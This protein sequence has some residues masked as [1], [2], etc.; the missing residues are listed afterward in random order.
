[1]TSTPEVEIREFHLGNILS[2]TTGL[3]VSPNHI[4]G[5]W[6]I[7]NWMTRDNLYT[8]QL[9]RASKE[10]APELLRQHPE[11]AS[12][13]VPDE[14]SGEEAVLAWL[15]QQVSVYGEYLEITPL[16]DGEHTYIDPIDEIRMMR[17]DAPIIAVT[18][19]TGAR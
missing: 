2:I 15:A 19:E 7:L 14:F 8:H 6:E 5:I 4:G 9:P 3:L 1:M 13:E 11:L 17:P 10:C 12:V 16:A 18:P